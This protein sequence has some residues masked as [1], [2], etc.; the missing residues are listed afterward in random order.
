MVDQEIKVQ[1]LQL[2]YK[3]SRSIAEELADQLKLSRQTISKVRQSFWDKGTIH[4][5][6]LLLNPQALNLQYFFMEIKTNPAEPELLALLK[7]IPE[8]ISIDGVLGDYALIVKLEARTKQEFSKILHSMD[9]NIAR[10]MFQSY[11]IIETLEVF[12][13]GGVIL[14]R[15]LPFKQLSD[16]KWQLLKLLTKNYNPNKWPERLLRKEFSREKQAQY[17]EKLNLSREFDQFIAD[18]LIERFTITMNPIMPDFKMKYF[19]RIKPNQ[20]GDYTELAEMLINEPNITE[21]YRTGEDSGLLAIIRTKGV[22]S[23]RDFIKLIYQKYPIRNTHTTVVVRNIFP[24]FIHPLL[25]RQKPNVVQNER[26]SKG[27]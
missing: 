23:F 21:L 3:N 17:L 20:V 24:R 13:L 2:L 11:R 7:S 6:T 18:N 16:E 25:M 26:S 15:N 19:M 14:N 1:L 22:E 12:K 8:I 27:P 4:N 10:T 5:P 9:Q